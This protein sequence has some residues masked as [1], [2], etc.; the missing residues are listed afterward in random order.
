MSYPN[1]VRG[2][3]FVS[4]RPPFDH[5]KMFNTHYRGICKVLGRFKKNNSQKHKSGGELIKHGECA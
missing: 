4:M 3:L 5:L 1:F 2:P